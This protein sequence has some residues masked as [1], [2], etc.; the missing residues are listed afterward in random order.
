MAKNKAC[1][2]N[3]LGARTNDEHNDCG[4]VSSRHWSLGEKEEVHMK[5]WLWM[6]DESVMAVLRE[7]SGFGVL[8][9]CGLAICV[10]L[11]AAMRM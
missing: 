11:D 2:P 6:G 9:A 10:W 8:V 7:I 5:F 1:N 3:K 4:D